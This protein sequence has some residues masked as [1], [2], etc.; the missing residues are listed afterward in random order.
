LALRKANLAARPSKCSFGF[1]SLEFLEHIVGNGKIKPTPD[2]IE[3]I[4]KFPVPSTKKQIRSFVG[5]V[6]FYRKFIGN[7]SEYTAPLTD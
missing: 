3:T 5:C 7:F 1:K 6:G 2:K 4:Q